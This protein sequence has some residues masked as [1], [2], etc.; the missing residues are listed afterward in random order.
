MDDWGSLVLFHV[1]MMNE[2]AVHT[3][4]PRPR[5][6]T[7]LWMTGA[8]WFYLLVCLHRERGR[9]PDSGTATHG[10]KHL[11]GDWVS[12]VLQWASYYSIFERGRCTDS[13]TTTHGP[14]HLCGDWVSMVLLWFYFRPF[15]L[16]LLILK[17]A[18]G[19]DLSVFNFLKLEPKWKFMKHKHFT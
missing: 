12:M 13:G 18:G 17:V 15:C 10:P 1:C 6:Q 4:V 8:P 14:K 7:P 11:C 9:C 5:A 16:C 2:A 3:L 19:R